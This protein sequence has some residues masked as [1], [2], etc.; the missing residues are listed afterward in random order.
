MYVFGG[1]ASGTLSSATYIYDPAAAAGT[2]WTTGA[3][4]P[5]AGAYGDAITVGDHIYYAGMS[6]ATVD[7]ADVY[8]YDPV[9]DS[10]TTMPSL[11][12]PRG[13]ARLHKDA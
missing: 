3:D 2:R 4:A 12:T 6:G 9:A 1:S 7:L 10:W 13:G 5:V 11:N 8:R